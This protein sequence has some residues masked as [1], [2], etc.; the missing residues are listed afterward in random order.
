MNYNKVK[1]L[2]KR[3]GFN[4]NRKLEIYDNS[5]GFDVYT[6]DYNNNLVLIEF[7]YSVKVKKVT[8]LY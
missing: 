8:V 7:T 1:D 6:V 5:D 4:V 2:L 3:S